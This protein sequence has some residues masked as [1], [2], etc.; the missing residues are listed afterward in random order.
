MRKLDVYPAYLK[1]PSGRKPDLRFAKQLR[2]NETNRR[3]MASTT[4]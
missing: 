3:S 4:N 2:L 1:Y